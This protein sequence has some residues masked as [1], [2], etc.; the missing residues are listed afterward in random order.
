MTAIRTG[1][2]AEIG[3][4]IKILTHMP[5]IFPKL[6][7]RAI[8]T[9]RGIPIA[10]ARAMPIT[11]DRREIETAVL[12]F[13]VGRMVMPA[14]ST[15]ENGGM[16]VESFAWPI[17]SQTMNQMASEKTIGTFLPNKVI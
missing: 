2:S 1:T 9:P 13:A 17:S 5:R 6:A 15:P 7:T 8:T 10:S 4:L 11:K 12:N 14:A 3:A 16:I